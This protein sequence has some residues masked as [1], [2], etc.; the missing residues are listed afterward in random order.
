MDISLF[1]SR[2]LF[3][4]RYLFLIG[5]SIVTLLVAYFSQ[6]MP[7]TYTVETS[8]YTGIVSATNIS[9][10]ADGTTS[11]TQNVSTTFDNLI[12]LITS[13][14]TLE[15]VSLKLFAMNM[16]Y[17][18]PSKDNQYITAEHYKE[19]QEIVPN[20]VKKMIDK[21]SVDKT[22]ANLIRLG[23]N[24]GSNFI[25]KLLNGDHP[26]YSFK[27]LSNVAVFRLQSS[28]LIKISYTNNDPGIT[29]NTVKLF[30][31][32][33]LKSYN[34]LR[35]SSTNDV[36][37][38]F[39]REVAKLKA[40]LNGKEDEMTGFSVANGII[41][42][43]DQTKSLA[44]SYE[45]F[46]DRYED[47]MKR[48]NSAS[49]L[50]RALED[51]MNARQKAFLTNKKFLKLL[52]NITEYNSKITEIEMFSSD[53]AKRN[54]N[55]LNEYK[56]KLKQTEGEV[57]KISKDIDLLK[58][59]KEGLSLEEFSQ[60]WVQAYIEYTKSMAELA[61][62]DKRRIYYEDKYKHYSPIGTELKRRER[63]ISVTEDS[64]L[65][66]LHA[67]NEAY[68]RKKNIQMTTANLN[69]VSEPMF[70]LSPNKSKRMLYI[71]AA[72][73]GSLLFLIFYKLMIELLDR[74][75]RDGERTKRLTG[76][77][78]IGAFVGK[79]ELRYRGY[80]KNWNRVSASNIA[81][82]M[83]R[84]IS[85]DQ[86][87]Y[88]NIIS[89]DQGEGKTYVMKYLQDEYER[90]GM[91]V[92]TISVTNEDLEKTGFMLSKDFSCIISQEEASEYN[93][94]F[95]EYPEL[96]K[97]S[98]PQALIKGGT[99]NLIVANA[100]R[101]WRKSD[102]DALTNFKEDVGKIPYK[103]MLNNAT[104]YD[105]EDFTGDLPPEKNDQILNTKFMHIGL[106]AKDIP[107][108]K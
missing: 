64:Y 103:L 17:G 108:E 79:G 85:S 38:Y 55:K 92:K 41:N 66:M 81:S 8:I 78:I 11:V 31:E 80:S 57:A 53:Q 89:M 37:A 107:V 30:N 47:A 27:A 70:P 20:E 34:D 3:R 35:Y 16:I 52:D 62:L 101:V 69:T 42:Y 75:L 23:R 39:E 40:L 76:E 4:N 46:E 82:K 98:L 14:S 87:N 58:Y 93:I 77:S 1:I 71:I 45:N 5:S 100:R 29:T 28:D 61:V 105:V 83:L 72:F 12:N 22:A 43:G 99:F 15:K 94:I 33:L 97:N 18:D 24:S 36:I 88:I 32:E 95:I 91:A 106:T 10:S 19:L 63:D 13:Q 25:Y 60:Q 56:D 26:H 49:E 67:L 74:T 65:T 73:F 54:D 68:L 48:F 2:F 9:S 59:S 6:F 51:Q 84:Y 44:N 90:L 104:R 21:S 102:T 86:P 96:L 50:V 7:K